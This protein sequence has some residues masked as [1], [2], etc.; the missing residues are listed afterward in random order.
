MLCRGCGEFGAPQVREETRGISGIIMFLSYFNVELRIK[1]SR[2]YLRLDTVCFSDVRVSKKHGKKHRIFSATGRPLRLPSLQYR[3][4]VEVA[5]W[6]YELLEPLF[7]LMAKNRWHPT[8]GSNTLPSLPSVC[9]SDTLRWTFWLYDSLLQMD[10]R[11]FRLVVWNLKLQYS[12]DSW[13]SKGAYIAMPRQSLA[14]SSRGPLQSNILIEWDSTGTW[15]C[16]KYQ[17]ITSIRPIIAG[18][19]SW[20]QGNI[21]RKMNWTH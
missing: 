7:L 9:K 2:V 21:S 15:I 11:C 16:S 13:D 19:P 18:D 8:C 10:K 5:S 6:C 14:D 1:Q 4:V 20:W 12:Q 17:Q 3:I